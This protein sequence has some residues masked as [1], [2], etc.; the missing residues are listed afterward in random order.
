MVTIGSGFRAQLLFTL[1]QSCLAPTER[2]LLLASGPNARFILFSH[3]TV[4]DYAYTSSTT[5]LLAIHILDDAH[6]EIMLTG[7]WPSRKRL[8]VA[9]VALIIVFTT[10]LNLQYRSSEKL[11]RLPLPN[12]SDRNTTKEPNC[13]QSSILL[14]LLRRGVIET[15]PTN[16]E[17]SLQL[18]MQPFSRVSDPAISK[19]Y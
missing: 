8:A 15:W 13:E 11:S 14:P 19:P 3:Q 1:E 2:Q 4:D 6:P 12:S 7:S 17:K 18:E 9:A 10:L 5:S 16:T